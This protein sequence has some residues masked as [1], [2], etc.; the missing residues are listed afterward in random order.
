MNQQEKGI[1]ALIGEQQQSHRLETWGETGATN[2]L[3]WKQTQDVLV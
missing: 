2:V 1:C 3:D